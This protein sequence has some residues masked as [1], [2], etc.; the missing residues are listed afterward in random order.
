MFLLMDKPEFITNLLHSVD[1]GTKE[2][3][4]ESQIVLRYTCFLVH[5]LILSETQITQLQ[6]SHAKSDRHKYIV[7][8]K[9]RD[10]DSGARRDGCC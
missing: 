9:L 3:Q 6:A 1:N 7:A 8:W 5:L 4:A 2:V 10:R